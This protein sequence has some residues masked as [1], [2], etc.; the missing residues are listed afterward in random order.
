[1]AQGNFGARV[2]RGA[3]VEVGLGGTNARGGHGKGGEGNRR[4][5]LIALITEAGGP[6]RL[7]RQINDGRRKVKVVLGMNVGGE[8]MGQ[9]QKGARNTKEE[10][11]N[12]R[13]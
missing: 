7:G 3:N 1:M 13:G 4:G 8:Y 2:R 9:D 5:L 12:D 10:K 11:V 6:C